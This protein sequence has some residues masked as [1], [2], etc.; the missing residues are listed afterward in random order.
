MKIQLP[1]DIAVLKIWGNLYKSICDRDH[2]QHKLQT[3][4]I[5][6]QLFHKLF[7]TDASAVITKCF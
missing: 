3:V 4:K 2:I 1:F 7:P 6:G 5:S